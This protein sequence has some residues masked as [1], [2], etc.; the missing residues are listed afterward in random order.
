MYRLWKDINPDTNWDE[1][2]WDEV[3]PEEK[4][5]NTMKSVKVGLKGKS[6]PQ[7]VPVLNGVVAGATGKV[8]LNMSPV[9]LATLTT[10]AS[11]G[12]ALLDEELQAK[13]A[14][15]TTRTARRNKFKEAR[16]L[17]QRYAIF[18]N[19]V[20]AGDKLSLQA[21]GLDVVETGGPVGVL[22]AP[23]NLR[24]TPGLLDNSIDLRWNFVTGR[25][26]YTAE[27]SE[28]AN[29]PWAQI[30]QG[31]IA[32]TSCGSLVSGKEYFFRVRAHGAAGPGAW[33]DI[34]KRRAS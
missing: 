7:I 16:V 13:E 19:S 30:Y 8:E 3:L 15:L 24:S 18:A 11:D 6:D 31:K 26:W 17:A 21:I 32:R 23:A 33:S 5:I 27:C 22:A 4:G 2:Q 29:G 1:A 10:V 25:D 34:T 14:W 20:Y 12:S 9:P 28:G